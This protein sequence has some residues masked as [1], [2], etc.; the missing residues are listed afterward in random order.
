[1]NSVSFRGGPD[2]PK[3]LTVLPPT[4]LSRV[5]ERALVCREETRRRQRGAE[6]LAKD[7]YSNS[8]G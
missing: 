2:G 3:Q 4:R 7:K 8:G 5:S 6:I 1:L